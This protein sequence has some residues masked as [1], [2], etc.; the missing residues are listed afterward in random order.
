MYTLFFLLQMV[1]GLINNK[2]PVKTKSIITILS[3]F[4]LSSCL[5][6]CKE[7]EQNPDPITTKPPVTEE[8]LPPITTTGTGTFGCKVNGKVWVAKSNTS[9]PNLYCSFDKNDSN[10][11]GVNG[12]IKN[13]N[14]DFLQVNFRWHYS[15]NS[16]NF[17]LGYGNANSPKAGYFD[18]DKNIFGETDSLRGGEVTILR[19]DSIKQIISGTFYFDCIN[20]ETGETLKITDGRFDGYYTY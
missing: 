7:K 12:Y 17:T 3:I 6:S 13:N 16:S 14:L 15:P 5:W 4:A 18:I 2:N 19:F 1:L 8:Q 9:W 11:I 10:C 20:Q